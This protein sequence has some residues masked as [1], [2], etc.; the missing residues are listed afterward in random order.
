MYQY[1]Q[2]TNLCLK[3]KKKKENKRNDS[4][5]WLRKNFFYFPQY[6]AEKTEG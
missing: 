6:E 3:L 5:K 2:E 1:K 4:S